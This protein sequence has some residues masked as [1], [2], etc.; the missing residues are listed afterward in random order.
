ME[1]TYQANRIEAH[2]HVAWEEQGCFCHQVT[3]HRTAS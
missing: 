3:V 2:W 1:K